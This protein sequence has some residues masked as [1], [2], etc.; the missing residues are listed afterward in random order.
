M[1]YKNIYQVP[2]FSS[3]SSSLLHSFPANCKESCETKP[4]STCYKIYLF[5]LKIKHLVCRSFAFNFLALCASCGAAAEPARCK[6]PLLSSEPRS[7][8]TL[9]TK[10]DAALKVKE[11]FASHWATERKKESVRCRYE[12][13]RRKEAWGVGGG[14]RVAV[15]SLLGAPRGNRGVRLPPYSTPKTNDS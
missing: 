10:R 11:W 1:L 5:L 15:W 6:S 3:S 8:L 14:S 2:S 4:F 9:A 13:R 12:G 7:T